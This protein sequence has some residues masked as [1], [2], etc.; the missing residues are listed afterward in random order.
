MCSQINWWGQSPALD[1]VSFCLGPEEGSGVAPATPTADGA[2]A[3]ASPAATAASDDG[4]ADGSLPTEFNILVLGAG[5]IRH[6]LRT[7][8]VARRRGLR[9]RFWVAERGMELVAR[10]L[11]QLAL[12]YAPAERIGLQLKAEMFLEILGNSHVRAQTA[13]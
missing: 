9:V 12:A 2:A 13:E 7:G 4:H 5:D 11:L 8:A 3:S 10:Q 1:L 6:I